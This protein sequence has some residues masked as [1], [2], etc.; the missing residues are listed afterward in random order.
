[1]NNSGRVF[2][3]CDIGDHMS[4]EQILRFA[5]LLDE[6]VKAG[7]GQ[8]T[9]TVNKYHVNRVLVMFDLK[10]HGIKKDELGLLNPKFGG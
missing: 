10:F 8:V 1:M 7:Y 6:V 3:P 4:D 2:N 5:T 9:I